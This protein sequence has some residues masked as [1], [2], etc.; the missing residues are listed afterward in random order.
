M[1]SYKENLIMRVIE[2]SEG[3]SWDSAVS[4]WE[5]IDCEEDEHHE[6][7]CICGKEDLRF[8]FTIQ[9]RYNQH[10]LYPIGSRCIRKFERHDLDEITSIHESLFKLL[11]AL[12]N[13]ERIELTS[14]YFSRKLLRYLYDNDAFKANPYNHGD[15]YNDYQFIVDMFNQ[16]LPLTQR[17]QS[18]V[19][20]IIL[21][22]IKPYLESILA[23]KIH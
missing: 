20:A 1:G 15:G 21:N 3:Q 9:N 13:R 14:E 6:S 18:K 4:E 23:D 2:A 8:L 17:Q 11:H 16:R 5:I 19:N 12:R 22:S 10:V 7:S